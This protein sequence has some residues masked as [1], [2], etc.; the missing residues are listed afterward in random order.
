MNPWLGFR[1]RSLAAAIMVLATAVPVSAQVD[2]LLFLK[3]AAPNVI[4]VVDTAHRMQ[5]S[6]PT[7]PATLATSQATSHYHDPFIYTKN[8]LAP[9]WQGSIGVTDATTIQFY[10]RRTT[11]SNTPA[12]AATSSR[13]QRFRPWATERRN[14]SACSRRGP[15]CRSR[16]PRCIKRSTRTGR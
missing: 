6:A 13:L 10:R 3:T 12:A 14:C 2:P 1:P 15:G 9:I 8:A 5:R 4:L 16:V 11:T 7:N